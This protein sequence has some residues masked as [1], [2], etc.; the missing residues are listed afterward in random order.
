VSE[1]GWRGSVERKRIA[2]VCPRCHHNI[3]H[4]A[5]LFPGNRVEASCADCGHE[6]KPRFVRDEWNTTA[7]EAS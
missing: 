6:W 2:R 7:K 1:T 4:W 3:Y 5:H